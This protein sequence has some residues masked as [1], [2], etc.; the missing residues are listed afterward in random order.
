[1]PIFHDEERQKRKDIAGTYT[2]ALGSRDDISVPR[3]KADRESGWHLYVVQLNPDALSIGRNQFIEELKKRGVMTSVH[4]IPLHKHPFYRD[5]FDY[6]RREFQV[7]EAVYE[8]VIS[9]PIYPGM[10]NEDVGH[11]IY[12]VD[13]VLQRFRA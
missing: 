5:T 8:R 10:S 6:D 13:D 4:F 11:V 7:A 1:M 3:I 12:A 9:L 2:A